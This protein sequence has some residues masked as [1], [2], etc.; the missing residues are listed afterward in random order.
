MKFDRLTKVLLTIIAVGLWGLIIVLIFP[1]IRASSLAGGRQA[2]PTN[3]VV[4]FDS[5]TVHRL[6]V[7]NQKGQ[8]QW[9]IADSSR[10]PPPV[11][12]GKVYERAIAPTG[13]IFYDYQGNEV[14]G[15]VY[16]ERKGYRQNAIIFDYQNSD[17]MGFGIQDNRPESY[18]AGFF[19]KDPVPLKEDIM[20]RE[21]GNANTDRALMRNKNGNAAIILRDKKGNDRI[22]LEVTK[23]GQATIQI[24]NASG[25]VVSELPNK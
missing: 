15:R 12:N 1:Q 18:S 3:K 11:L 8:P 4:D 25:K 23:A 9:V 13:A 14:G 17:G 22:K 20:E 6:N 7:V 10:F 21:G 19:I 5:L 16:S 2:A 24:Y